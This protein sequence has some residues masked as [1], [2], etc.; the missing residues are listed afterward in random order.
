MT[1]MGP[2]PRTE[3]ERFWEKVQI[4]QQ[5]ECWLWLGSTLPKGYGRFRR[6]NPRRME[7]AHRTAFRLTHNRREPATVLRHSCDNP[8]CCNPNHLEEG[9]SADNS[10][11]MKARAR[12]RVKLTDADVMAIRQATGTYVQ[13]AK[14]FGVTP[15][16][17]GSLR[18]RIR[19]NKGKDPRP[20]QVGK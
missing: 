6:Q 8:R 1:R 3:E 18:R 11:D 9:N 15:S 13:I 14:Q 19:R 17:V 7:L 12:S 2:V 4:G 20:S 5:D 16:Y 10:A